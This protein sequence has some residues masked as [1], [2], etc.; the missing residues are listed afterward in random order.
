MKKTHLRWFSVAA[1][2]LLT[3]SIALFSACGG[4]D[5]DTNN[6]G[7]STYSVT[8]N[9]DSGTPAPQN[10][11]G[12]ASG[13]LIQ[14]PATMTKTGY[15]FKGWFTSSEF[16]GQAVT[17]PYTLTGNVAFWAKW[18]L[19][20]YTVTWNANGGDPAPQNQTDVVSGTPIEEPAEMTK[21]NSD[22]KGRFTS[23]GFNGQAVTFPYTLTG[24]VTFWAK[25][26]L[27][28]CTV[29]FD[30]NEA[31][32]GTAPDAMPTVN[33]KLTLPGNTGN[34]VK[35]DY[36]F[37]G[38]N[39]RADGK[40]T[41]YSAGA[42]YTTTGS[43]VILYA[44]WTSNTSDHVMFGR[45]G[46]QNYV[47][48]Q[49]VSLPAGTYTLGVEYQGFHDFAYRN[50]EIHGV[51]AATGRIATFGIG[52][53]GG[54]AW[55]NA[56]EAGTNKSDGQLYADTWWRNMGANKSPAIFLIKT[57]DM[58]S[59]P[60]PS[61][62]LP[63]SP[64]TGWQILEIE[65]FT[66]SGG[67]YAVFVRLIVQNTHA[68]EGIFIKSI[69]LNAE[70]STENLL[71]NSDFSD[72]TKTRAVTSANSNGPNTLW[73]GINTGSGN[74]TDIVWY[75]EVSGESTIPCWSRKPINQVGVNWGN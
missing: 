61:P 5:D 11:T 24:N 4:A 7:G 54:E 70:D 18:D 74:F 40:G 28:D 16:T 3:C 43:N 30:R 52:L 55:W 13:T 23:S 51:S 41:N 1:A 69:W 71:V 62:I 63:V 37:G 39:T 45:G 73:Y 17:F 47:M 50:D 22:F 53:P 65:N 9:A 35:G 42:S 29:S 68:N 8:W 32:S 66:L 49:P 31:D 20:N 25:W 12:V 26:D 6:G 15:D 58:A 27:K 10:Q 67:N 2:I 33:G 38:W 19:K 72:Q 75:Y 57:G 46:G 60:N 34:L 21:D 48:T 64:D 56:T 36:K 14:A 59:G 44:R